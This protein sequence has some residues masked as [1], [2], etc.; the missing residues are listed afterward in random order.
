VLCGAEIQKLGQKTSAPEDSASFDPTGRGKT[1]TALP[2]G[3]DIV[4]WL[5]FSFCERETLESFA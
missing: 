2:L 4:A 5:V 3:I 1:Y